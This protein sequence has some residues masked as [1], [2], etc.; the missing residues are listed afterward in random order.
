MLQQPL[1]Y[2]VVTF[3][4]LEPRRTSRTQRSFSERVL[5]LHHVLAS[6]S[7]FFFTPRFLYDPLARKASYVSVDHCYRRGTEVQK[8]LE[9]EH[10]RDTFA[11][12]LYDRSLPYNPICREID[13]FCPKAET[14]WEE[15]SKELSHSEDIR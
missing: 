13:R 5:S 6:L 11:V 1:L 3:Y 10:R 15:R 14:E 12:F 8:N 2:A 4:L 7:F 9:V